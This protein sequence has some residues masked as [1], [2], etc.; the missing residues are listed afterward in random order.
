MR[1][2]C[3]ALAAAALLALPCAAP[4]KDRKPEAEKL[5]HEGVDRWSQGTFDEHRQA[6][7]R[8]EQAAKLT[9]KDTKVL[10][11]LAQ[12][13]LDAG[14]THDAKETYEHVTEL[15]PADPTG[16]EGLGRVWKRD[17]LATLARASL[18]KS[19]HYFDEAVRLDPK[20]AEVWTALAVLRIERGDTAV[21]AR[22]AEQAMQSAPE[23]GGPTVAGAYLAYRAGR[24]ASAESL[25]TLAFARMAPRLAA[26]FRDVTPLVPE[27]DG[28]ALADMSPAAR[29]EYARKFWSESD[30]DP[31]L[32][33]NAAR[34]EYWARVAHATLLYSD[35]WEPHW[36]M[37]AELYVRYGPPEHIGYQPPG[38]ALAQR[39]NEYDHVGAFGVPGVG[40]F[41][42][43]V[44]DADP[45]WYP[46]HLQ[47]WEY[48]Q[49]GMNVVLEDRA[50]SQHYELPRN[51]W[52]ETDA[53]PDPATMA[54]NGLL[55]TAGGRATFTPFPPG[56]QPLAVQGSVSAF[57]GD[58][59]PRLL[60][61]VSAPGTPDRALTAVC[62]VIDSSEHEVQRASR[63]L[64]ASRCDPA[65]LRAGDFTFDLPPGRYRVA[66]SV[67]D[68]ASGRGVVRTR[69]ALAPVS[70][71]L[72]ISDLVLVCGPLDVEPVAGSVRLD[73]NF[74]HTIA[75][76]EPLLA[77]FEV[78]QLEPDASGATR[79]EYEY[80]VRPLGPDT[81]PWFK[82]M[83]PL[84]ASEH[85]DVRTPQSGVGPT[86]RQYLSVPAE[87][88]Q[89]GRYRLEVT[90][91]DHASGATTRR[92]V[93]FVKEPEAEAPPAGTVGA[94]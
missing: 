4:A 90:V 55:A 80:A 28:E 92:D 91:K 46:L 63:S 17:W 18:E 13:Y 36:D 82:R 23:L 26:R 2:P 56:V 47:V 78:Y 19:I 15:S 30:P 60:A 39:P 22:C 40:T 34:L 12:E 31:T 45:M 72:S 6:I 94:R 49:L 66:M 43:R 25:F 64:G 53:A 32:R 75:A 20:R 65:T 77:Y 58:G 74:A 44:G 1:R 52:A 42:R 3:I 5:V 88:L 33:V 54:R 29:A 89:P 62:V 35:T 71:K 38:F 51:S 59:G 85:L 68:G 69:R 16:W 84:S 21:A 81:R 61:H 86:R 37:R 50:I 79:F 70:G 9:P 57:Q 48:P 8:L 83:L 11:E 7:A 27:T 67:S 87:S 24:L 41:V 73:P 93:E 10:A 76:H 14:F